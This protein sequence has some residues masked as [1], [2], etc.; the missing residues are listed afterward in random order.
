MVRLIDGAAAE[1]KPLKELFDQWAAACA[2]GTGPVQPIIVAVSGGATR[3]GL[4]GAAVLDRVL[5]AQQKD[6][7]ALFAISSVS[8]GS[9]GVAGAMTLLSLENLPCRAKGVSALRPAEL[10]TVPLA[11]DALGPLLGGWLL[12]DIPDGSRIFKVS[13]G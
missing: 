9:L 2:A 8:G 1:R 11:G 3:A 7:P 5:E 4:W 6:G 10:A 12:N 13:V